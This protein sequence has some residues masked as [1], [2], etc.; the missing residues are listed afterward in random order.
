MIKVIAF[1]YAG[2]LSPGPMTQWV[3]ENLNISDDKFALYKDYAHKWDLGEMNI[4]QVYEK[5]SIITGIPPHLIW[6]KFYENSTYNKQV[7][8]III[9]LKKHYGVI[10]FS[11]FLGEL[12]RKLLEKYKI[13]NLFDEI[14][15]SSE[16]KM[17]KPNNDFFKLL[18]EKAGV[19]KDEILFIDDRKDNVKAALTF[20][21]KSILF[22]NAKD[23]EQNLKDTGLSF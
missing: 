14:I 18:I 23:L 20:G 5:L 13:T 17:K 19:K 8:N 11:N 7:V 16:H 1:D 4:E 15:I 2:V 21:I 9:K 10:L 6:E 22:K 12:L 3:K